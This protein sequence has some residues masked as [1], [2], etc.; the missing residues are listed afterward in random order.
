MNSIIRRSVYWEEARGKV[1]LL[2]SLQR[3][4]GQQHPPYRPHSA[5]PAPTTRHRNHPHLQPC[6]HRPHHPLLACTWLS[7]QLGSGGWPLLEMA[8]QQL[9]RL[10]RRM[11]TRHRSSGSFQ[12]IRRGHCKPQPMQPVQ[13]S[14]RH[15][16]TKTDAYLRVCARACYCGRHA[17]H[18]LI[19]G[20][21]DHI[22]DPNLCSP[23]ATTARHDNRVY[24]TGLASTSHRIHIRSASKPQ[25]PPQLVTQPHA[26]HGRK[27]KQVQMFNGHGESV[28]VFGERLSH[29]A[30]RG[31]ASAPV[32]P[33]A[34]AVEYT[35]PRPASA[36]VRGLVLPLAVAGR[37]CRGGGRARRPR[38][39]KC[40]PQ[41]LPSALPPH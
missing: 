4:A 12:G 33:A 2:G 41:R 23:V 34:P 39:L 28:S 1:H 22:R 8:L 11:L 21:R 17:T 16:C 26:T 29:T 25:P 10:R 32:C 37:G 20:I 3:R 15:T 31:S 7:L 19:M 6:R 38:L 9:R 35:R 13:P 30:R 40:L 24:F 5:Q 27:H 18:I 36:V 14:V